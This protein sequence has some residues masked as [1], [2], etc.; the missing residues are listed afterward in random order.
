L[1]VR[2]D[3]AA[4]LVA[5]NRRLATRELDPGPAAE[6]RHAAQERV[7]RARRRREQAAAGGD[8]GTITPA[9]LA[10][11]VGAALDA[12]TLVVEEAVSNR[13]AV[14]EGVPRSLPGTL[15]CAGGA[16]LGYGLGAALGVALS[17]PGREVVALI[18][19]GS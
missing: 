15:F 4:A 17:A 16:G 19:D 9:W 6:R 10:Q 1:A 5:L 7:E 3:P 11:S 8:D 13:L 2:A 18:G 12:E 14:F